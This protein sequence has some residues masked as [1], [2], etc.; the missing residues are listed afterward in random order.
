MI[1]LGAAESKADTSNEIRFVIYNW[2]T[3]VR[4]IFSKTARDSRNNRTNIPDSDN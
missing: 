4:A 3:F 2:P 1:T